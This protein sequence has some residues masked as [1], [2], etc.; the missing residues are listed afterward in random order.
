MQL[1]NHG[2]LLANSNNKSFICRE[3]EVAIR[4]SLTID[5]CLIIKK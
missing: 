4:S 2:Q 3:V 1:D 5:D